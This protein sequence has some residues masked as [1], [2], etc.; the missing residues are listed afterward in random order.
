LRAAEATAIDPRLR[1][2]RIEVQRHAGRRRLRRV[3][4]AGLLLAVAAGFLVALRSPLLDVEQV[5]VAGG[6]RTPAEEVLAQA[7]IEPGQQ[8]VDLDLGQVGG[9]VAA[10]PWV[11]EVT[12]RRHLGGTVEIVVTERVASAIVG[13][14]TA[15]VLVDDEG[16]AL[17]RAEAVPDVAEGLV[18]VQ[19]LPG[20]AVPGAFL[21]AE[22]RAALT[23]AG[24]LAAAVPG[25]IGEVV[26]G[27]ELRATLVQGGEV[28]FG[29]TARLP[30]KLRSL[31]TVLAQVDLAC[32]GELD[33]RAPASPV[34]T[35][36]EGCS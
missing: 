36:R 25:A 14:G 13:D 28:R 9:R 31:A 12:V 34:L 17:A 19:G 15:A 4:D 6:E 26:L 30:A 16:R 20:G 10:L 32:L 21:P 3:V 24:E 7:A 23:L 1:A 27:E 11:D 35:R 29:D 18:R 22:S 5:R 2:R 8:L 33:L